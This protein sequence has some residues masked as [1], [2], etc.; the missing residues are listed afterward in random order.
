M[1][2]IEEYFDGRD[3]FQT[4]IR[5]TTYAERNFRMVMDAHD[6]NPVLVFQTPGNGG[7][8][9]GSPHP[10]DTSWVASDIR[11]KPRKTNLY[12]DVDVIYSPA[13]FFPNGFWRKTIR[14]TARQETALYSKVRND[15]G[16]FRDEPIGPHAYFDS[17]EY[18]QLFN[19]NPRPKL[20]SVDE[21]RTYHTVVVKNHVPN[22]INLFR[23]QGAEGRRAKGITIDRSYTEITYQTICTQLAKPS[24]I[25]SETW[26]DT[27]NDQFF[28]GHP[29]DAVRTAEI[30][31]DE[32]VGVVEGQPITGLVYNVALSFLVDHALHQPIIQPE[33]FVSDGNEFTIMNDAGEAVREEYFAYRPASL[34]ELLNQFLPL[35]QT[36]TRPSR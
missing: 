19:R 9:A 14:T 25:I 33:T 7:V 3:T 12:I 13:I 36:I 34:T 15:D 35:R 4:G 32:T 31:I 5:G 17:F 26:K 6:D 28:E 11:L 24:N 16:S 2:T 22:R 1:P 8:P 23:V 20:P 10:W 21:S 18:L 29:P 27:T 30:F